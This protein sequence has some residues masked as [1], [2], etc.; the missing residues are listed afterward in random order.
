MKNYIIGIAGHKDSGKDITASM[1]NYIFAVGITKAKYIEWRTKRESFDTTYADRI[2]HFGDLP[3][4]ILS[5]MY[6]IPRSCFDSRKYKDEYWYC[7][8]TN[9]FFENKVVNKHDAYVKI[10]IEQLQNTTLVNIIQSNKNKFICIRLRTL[11]QHFATDICRNKLQDDI[12]IRAAMCRIVDKA[13][14]RRICIVPDVRFAN[15]AE[16]VRYMES[17]LYGGV[18]MLKRNN[19]DNPEHSSEVIDFTADYEIDNNGTIMKLFYNV[20]DVVSKILNK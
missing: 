10:T 4:D 1:I 19:N 18:I 6:N 8:N 16:A 5:V 15:E 13:I 17:S 20:L 7:F 12:W 9:S 11:M 14:S 3:K 2:I